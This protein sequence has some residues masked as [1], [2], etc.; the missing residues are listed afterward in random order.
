M[1][2]L[3]PVGPRCGPCWPHEPCYHGFNWLWPDATWVCDG[4]PIIQKLSLECFHCACFLSRSPWQQHPHSDHLHYDVM[5]WKQFLH[6]WPFVRGIHWSRVDSHNK[7]PVRRVFDDFFDGSL[8]RLLNEQSSCQWFQ[9]LLCPC[10]C[11]CNVFCQ[12]AK[13]VKPLR[14]F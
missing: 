8:N 5:T 11:H 14:E 12:A 6:Y 1:G 3:G 4:C 7:E 13:F 9:T 10:V 2:H